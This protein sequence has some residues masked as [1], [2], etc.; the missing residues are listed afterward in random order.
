MAS[1]LTSAGACRLFT[2]IGYDWHGGRLQWYGIKLEVRGQVEFK[3]T[4]SR[5][6]TCQ[7]GTVLQTR[8]CGGPLLDYWMVD[9]LVLHVCLSGHTG[10]HVTVLLK[11]IAQTNLQFFQQC[12]ERSRRPYCEGIWFSAEALR[13]CT[14]SVRSDKR[15]NVHFPVPGLSDPKKNTNRRW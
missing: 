13:P 2:F 10:T 9:R 7:H 5:S 3:G 6:R 12:A 1:P 11:V 4:E 8:C 15:R 14:A